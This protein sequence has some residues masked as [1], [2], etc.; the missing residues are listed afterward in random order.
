MRVSATGRLWSSREAP[1]AQA[2]GRERSLG[3][4]GY[5]P[6]QL[7]GPDLSEVWFFI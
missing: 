6:A 5:H 7:A 3:L 2:A 4:V 1:Q